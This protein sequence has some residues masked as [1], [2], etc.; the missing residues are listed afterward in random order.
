MKHENGAQR[1]GYSALLDLSGWPLDILLMNTHGMAAWTARQASP[2]ATPP[3]RP[4]HMAVRLANLFRTADVGASLTAGRR[5]SRAWIFRGSPHRRRTTSNRRSRACFKNWKM[6]LV[7]LDIGSGYG[8]G[9]GPGAFL[10]LSCCFGPLRRGMSC[11]RRSSCR[12]TFRLDLFRCRARRRRLAWSGRLSLH[13]TSA[14]K[15]DYKQ[16]SRDSFTH[17]RERKQNSGFESTHFQQANA[18]A[19]CWNEPNPWEGA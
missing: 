5:R 6:S 15:P 10:D 3:T 7:G 2:W 18:D 1:R 17:V 16:K 9:F 12:R 13:S 8:I 4:E 14:G 19:R 11:G